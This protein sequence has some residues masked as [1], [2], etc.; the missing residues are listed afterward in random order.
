MN[1]VSRGAADAALGWAKAA[2]AARA[3]AGA[4]IM[5]LEASADGKWLVTKKS[6]TLG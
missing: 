1:S 6:R 2:L 5:G 3:P 4:A